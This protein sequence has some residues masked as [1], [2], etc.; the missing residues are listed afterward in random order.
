MKF[1]SEFDKDE[2]KEIII[3]N[4]Y[5]MSTDN[6]YLRNAFLSKVSEN[7]FYLYYTGG[8]GSRKGTCFHALMEEIHEKTQIE[9]YYE[10]DIRLKTLLKIMRGILAVIASLIIILDFCTGILFLIPAFILEM[11]FWALL[12]Y[13]NDYRVEEEVEFVINMLNAKIDK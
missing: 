10:V 3:K 5:S 8:L 12:N 11:F 9:G 2:I 1:I 4:T 7:E 6:F 13:K